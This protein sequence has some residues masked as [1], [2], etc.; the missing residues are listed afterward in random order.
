M[1]N[2]IKIAN[3]Y[4]SA[5][6]IAKGFTLHSLE[7]ESSGS[8]KFLFVFNHAPSIEKAINEF[9]FAPEEASEVLV[10]ARKMVFA[11]KKTK[12]VLYQN[13]T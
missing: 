1:S 2:T 11:I 3:F 7:R 8:N 5:F 9:N 6:L 13:K 10:D 4:I 12:E